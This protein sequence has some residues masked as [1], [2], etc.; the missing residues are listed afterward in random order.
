MFVFLWCLY[1]FIYIVFRIRICY[2]YKDWSEHNYVKY[3]NYRV[4]DKIFT[5]TKIGADQAMAEPMYY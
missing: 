4:F 2:A 5:W 3:H 1:G